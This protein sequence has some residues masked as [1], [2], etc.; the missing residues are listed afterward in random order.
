MKKK[1]K[2]LLL[3][4]LLLFVFPN[5]VDAHTLKA[6]STVGAVMHISPEDDPIAGEESG[7]FF[8]FKDTENKFKPEECECIISVYQGDIE[9]ISQPLFANNP[10]P[11]LTNAS[12][13]YTFPG[14][15]V[16]KIKI[17]GKPKTPGAFNE[18]SLEYDQRVERVSENP[19]NTAG[20][21][22]AQP[23]EE[24]WFAAYIPQFVGGLLVAA[25]A[26]FLTVMNK[27]QKNNKGGDK[28]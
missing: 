17:T 27:S 8:E 19:Q 1:L 26:V 20:H 16:Y 6:N 25:F 22:D 18:F 23:E 10:N 12:F 24:N 15:D 9:L 11:S 7:F 28:K 5:S 14:R 21:T 4:I 3:I 13:F 2:L